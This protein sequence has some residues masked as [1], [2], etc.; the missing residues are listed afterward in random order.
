VYPVT[1]A[2]Y[3][4]LTNILLVLGESPY[5][6]R[7][8]LEHSY[9]VKATPTTTAQRIPGKEPTFKPSSMTIIQENPEARFH[10]LPIG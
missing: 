2:G 6:A 9:H 8:E 1:D 4:E 7:F 3:F 10:T 5:P